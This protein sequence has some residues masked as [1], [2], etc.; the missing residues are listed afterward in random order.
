M[1]SI[2]KK[3][4]QIQ[5]RI[6]FDPEKNILSKKTVC[7]VL[8]RSLP[9]PQLPSTLI[10]Q[11]SHTKEQT[12]RKTLYKDHISNYGKQQ[13]LGRQSRRCLGHTHPLIRG[14]GMQAWLPGDVHSRTQQVMDTGPLSPTWETPERVPGSR[15][16][17]GPA[18]TVAGIWGVRQRKQDFC[19][20]L[21]LIFQIKMTKINK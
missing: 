20:S 8:W 6:H 7:A 19:L 12:P 17:S 1:L 18:R 2:L 21:S 13:A 3:N 4:Q 16:Q 14:C 11:R 5:S 15:V 10:L 9:H